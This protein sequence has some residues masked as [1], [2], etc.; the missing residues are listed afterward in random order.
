MVKRKAA[1]PPL[2]RCP[3]VWAALFF[4][5]NGTGTG[6][7]AAGDK[8]VNSK[9]H[10][11]LRVDPSSEADVSHSRYAL[12]TWAS[13]A[14]SRL[15]STSI[16]SADTVS[17]SS[18]DVSVSTAEG[19]TGLSASPEKVLEYIRKFVGNVESANADWFFF[20][21]VGSYLHLP[22]LLER[23]GA[24]DGTKPSLIALPGPTAYT[25]DSNVLF[26]MSK[27]L[28]LRAAA[29]QH[30]KSATEG[31]AN[32]GAN[33]P[34]N[35]LLSFLRDT[36]LNPPEDTVLDL[37]L[38][39]VETVPDWSV[40][41]PAVRENH[42]NMNMVWPSRRLRLHR[43]LMAFYPLTDFSDYAWLH[44]HIR[45]QHPRHIAPVVDMLAAPFLNTISPD[46]LYSRRQ[47]LRSSHSCFLDPVELNFYMKKIPAPLPVVNNNNPKPIF[48]ANDGFSLNVT[49][50]Y[51]RNLGVAENTAAAYYIRK[52]LPLRTPQVESYELWVVHWLRAREAGVLN[53]PATKTLLNMQD[54]ECRSEVTVP[55]LGV[56]SFDRC[57]RVCTQTSLCVA[58]SF[59]KK[60]RIP[61]S[62]A[63]HHPDC[64]PSPDQTSKGAIVARRYLDLDLKELVPFE[65]AESKAEAQRPEIP[66]T[67]ET[68]LAESKTPVDHVAARVAA[69]R[70][71][72]EQD[73]PEH[74]LENEAVS[75]GNTRNTKRNVFFYY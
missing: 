38:P 18:F 54:M 27:P 22:A 56:D 12:E 52:D 9:V 1:L 13:E 2:L 26:G 68:S 34:T 35:G 39:F 41:G 58:F 7:A 44:K 11:F 6:T 64:R 8:G 33:G 47:F 72:F 17:S 28:F 57:R 37:G 20:A 40:F 50:S 67:T 48:E 4:L 61:C 66:E 69:Q 51:V 42:L 10:I 65:L 19:L 5:F 75:N 55:I 53:G 32:G 15:A 49:A 36:L 23:L 45:K 3:G 43:C 70:A 24:Y 62:I 73:D 25:F 14:S 21:G 60:E 63:S 31:D 71:V 30:H 74:A 59:T 29:T 16:S 46:P